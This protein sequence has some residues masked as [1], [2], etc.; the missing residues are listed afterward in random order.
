MEIPFPDQDFDHGPVI[1][2]SGLIE[3]TRRQEDGAAVDEDMLRGCNGA[4]IGA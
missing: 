1:E 2:L 3:P 4:G